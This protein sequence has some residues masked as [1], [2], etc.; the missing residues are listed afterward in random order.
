M[1]N[2]ELEIKLVNA[3]KEKLKGQISDNGEL[4]M[5]RIPVRIVK[6][7]ELTATIQHRSFDV[8]QL[9]L[10]GSTNVYLAGVIEIYIEDEFKNVKP[11]EFYNFE[12]IGVGAKLN[13]DKE[14]EI[15]DKITL[16]NFNKR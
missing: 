2:N 16:S 11:S 13:A 9:L 5:F 7:G 10:H 8:N 14:F 6:I 1:K 4:L 15:Q 12:A 3:F